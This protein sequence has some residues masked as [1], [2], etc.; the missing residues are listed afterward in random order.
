MENCIINGRVGTL[1]ELKMSRNGK[2]YCSFS[3]AVDDGYDNEAKKQRTYWLKV[4]VYG[5]M[6]RSAYNLKQGANIQISG[7][8]PKVRF[9]TSPYGSL[10]TDSEGKPKFNYEVLAFKIGLLPDRIEYTP[11]AF[12]DDGGDGN[13][14]HKKPQ[15][16]AAVESSGVV[17]PHDYD[18]KEK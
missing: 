11:L 16:V 3:L 10:M 17:E 12:D 9:W 2:E 5:K 7:T 6:H 14:G 13:N 15:A 1:P 8:P 4:S 18:F